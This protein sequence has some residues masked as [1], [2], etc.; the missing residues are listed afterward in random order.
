MAAKS[1]GERLRSSFQFL[2]DFPDVGR[3]GRRPRTREWP[4]PDLPYIIVFRAKDDM[5]EIIGV[6]HGA[7]Q[8]RF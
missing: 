1:V 8:H 6:F 4:I 2:C 7:R 5:L 3:V